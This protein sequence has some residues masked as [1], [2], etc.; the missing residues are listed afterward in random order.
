VSICL[1]VCQMFR[2]KSKDGGKSLR[3]KLKVHGLVLPAGRR[4]ASNVNSLT[5]LVECKLF[6]R[7]EF[8]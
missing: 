5:A 7:F 2:A 3:D 8:K 4:K 6:K 1:N